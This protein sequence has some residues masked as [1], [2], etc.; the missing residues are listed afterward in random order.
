[1]HV[2]IICGCGLPKKF[3][4]NSKIL[5]NSPL[6]DCTTARTTNGR[7][8]KEELFSRFPLLFVHSGCENWSASACYVFDSHNEHDSYAV[9]V[10]KDGVVV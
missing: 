5:F 1:M 10:V 6:L 2:R 7:V 9:V 4:Y 8:M 3:F